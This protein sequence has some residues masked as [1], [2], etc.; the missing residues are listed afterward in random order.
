MEVIARLQSAIE[1]YTCRLAWHRRDIVSGGAIPILTVGLPVFNG[2]KYLADSIESLL[3]QTFSRFELVISDNASTDATKEICRKFAQQDPRVRYIRHAENI[4]ASGNFN[5]L[6]SQA[7]GRYF[8]WA[9]ADDLV[10]PTFL[11]RCVEVLDSQPN[12]VL[13]HSRTVTIGEDGS[14]LPNNIIRSSGAAESNGAVKEGRVYPPWQRFRD[15]LL[16]NGNPVFDTAVMDFYGVV[17]TDA[18]RHT[19][20]LKPYIGYE[21]V[22]M[23]NLSLRG[24]FWEVPEP[25]FI[26]RIHSKSVSSQTSA[27]AHSE[28]CDPRVEK[29]SYP[30]LK[31]LHGYVKTV[32]RSGL[33]FSERVMCFLVIGRYLLQISKWKRVFLASFFGRGHGDGN[34]EILRTNGIAVEVNGRDDDGS[35]CLT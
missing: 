14:E 16:G 7:R 33:P 31:Y 32:I 10:A 3:G 26:Y 23:A 22:L 2:E 12:Y 30:R 6:F 21:K 4:G 27:N 13:C 28:W 25:L 20:L 35:G 8:K 11:A 5:F 34:V 24:R 17:R 18:L 9:A 29:K 1:N 19:E 15:I